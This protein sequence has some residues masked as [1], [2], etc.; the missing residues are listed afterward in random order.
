SVREAGDVGRPAVLQENT[1]Q[2]KAFLAFA[3]KVIEQ[4]ELRNQAMEPT[5]KVE[6]TTMSGCSTK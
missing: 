4:V 6:I 3:D 2:S 1:P 5:K